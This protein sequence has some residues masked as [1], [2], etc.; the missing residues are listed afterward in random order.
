MSYQFDIS[1]REVV[2]SPEALQQFRQ[3]ENIRRGDFTQLT[4][5]LLDRCGIMAAMGY[6]A[7][8][9]PELSFER[10]YFRSPEHEGL[11]GIIA[12]LKERLT[13]VS[14]ESFTITDEYGRTATYDHPGF[15]SGDGQ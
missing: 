7:D 1:P 2:I 5:T 13:Y 15:G 6:G 10:P 4:E 11:P 9:K 12:R 8:W 14:A 3:D